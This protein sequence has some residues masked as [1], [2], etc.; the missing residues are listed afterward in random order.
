MARTKGS[1]NKHTT[2]ISERAFKVYAFMRTYLTR[3]GRPPPL[4]KV[5]KALNYPLSNVSRIVDSLISKGLS[6]YVPD[7]A[8]LT[9]GEL[10]A[11]FEETQLAY[12]DVMQAY[13]QAKANNRYEKQGLTFAQVEAEWDVHT[14]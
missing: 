11:I 1:T 2:R 5:A 7:Y 6:P 12:E 14:N 13:Q 9:Q 3:E 10:V 8:T 4:T